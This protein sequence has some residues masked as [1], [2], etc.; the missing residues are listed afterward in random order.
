MRW[1]KLPRFLRWRQDPNIPPGLKI[2][3]IGA[4]TTGDAAAAVAGAVVSATSANIDSV[5]P[6]RSLVSPH[7]GM[8]Q[9]HRRALKVLNSCPESP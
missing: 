9:A 5:R 8:N 6:N 4:T 7:A 2:V 1:T 3:S